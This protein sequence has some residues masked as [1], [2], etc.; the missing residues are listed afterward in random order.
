MIG[1]R[2]EI[3]VT[4]ILSSTA[5][6]QTLPC[7]ELSVGFTAAFKRSPPFDEQHTSVVKFLTMILSPVGEELFQ[8]SHLSA[9]L[10][11][12]SLAVQRFVWFRY[13]GWQWFQFNSRPDSWITGR[14]QTQGIT[15]VQAI[16][17]NY[18]REKMKRT[19]DSGLEFKSGD[20]SRKSKQG[21]I[22]SVGWKTQNDSSLQGGRKWSSNYFILYST[23]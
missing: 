9:E 10:L 13:S 15:P 6:S 19:L 11:P 12:D 8:K 23:F 18:G 21:E 7:K 5:E 4:N 17:Y 3:M 14:V 2:M 16:K 1:K 20:Q 22:Q